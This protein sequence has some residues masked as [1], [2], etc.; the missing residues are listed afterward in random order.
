MAAGRWGGFTVAKGGRR[1]MK[2]AGR[3]PWIIAGIVMLVSISISAA[4]VYRSGKATAPTEIRIVSMPTQQPTTLTTIRGEVFL[5]LVRGN[6]KLG[7]VQLWLYDANMMREITRA[8]GMTLDARESASALLKRVDT[9]KECMKL[10]KSAEEWAGWQQKMARQ[11]DDFLDKGYEQLQVFD[12]IQ[13]KNVM[14]SWQHDRANSEQAL[15][16]IVER[17]AVRSGEAQDEME[18]RLR[19][20]GYV[21]GELDRLLEAEE[22]KYSDA[23]MRALKFPDML[24]K[25]QQ[26]Q[27]PY[28]ELLADSDGRFEFGSVP[29]SAYTLVATYQD[30]YSQQGFYWVLPVDTRGRTERKVVLSQSNT[31]QTDRPTPPSTSTKATP[32]MR[33]DASMPA[34][35]P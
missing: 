35:T 5:K 33:P 8:Q 6:D 11:R 26:T 14:L 19:K 10:K 13:Q 30:P 7:G 2:D 32:T 12:P 27:R 1:R 18:K 31:Y 29:P 23:R 17:C 9:L 15:N 22:E 34:D 21:E 28:E 4:M 24:A 3:L 20:L 16:T 25:V